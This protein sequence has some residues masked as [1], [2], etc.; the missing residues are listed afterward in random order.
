MTLPTAGACDLVTVDF[1]KAANGTS[2]VR[3]QYVKNEWK[4]YGLVLA[5]KKGYGKL[6][7]LFDTANPGTVESGDPDLGSPNE[8][9]TNKGLGVGSGGEPGAPGENCSPLGYALIVQEKN[10]NM[11]V[12]DD[13]AKGGILFFKL[14]KQRGTYVKDIQLLDI[15]HNGSMVVMAYHEADEGLKRK[16]KNVENLGSNSVQTI[17]IDQGKV[18]WMKVKLIHSGAVPSITFCR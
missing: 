13:N 16:K 3:G 17:D 12:P 18:K 6:P 5:S 11:S 9:C 1:A 7:R 8:K 4:P 10:D 15:A 14:T 2:L